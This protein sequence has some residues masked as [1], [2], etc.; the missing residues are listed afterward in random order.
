MAVVLA[1]LASGWAA[2]TGGWIHAVEATDQRQNRLDVVAP[3]PA[4]GIALEQSF[5]A[6]HNGLAAVEL[7]LASSGNLSPQPATLTLRLMDDDNRQLA[8]ASWDPDQLRHN[9]PLRFNFAPIRNSAGQRFRLLLEG[10]EGNRVTV[11]AFSLDGYQPGELVSNDQ[12]QTGD[13]YFRTTYRYRLADALH[14]LCRFLR[15]QAGLGVVLLLL[16]GVPGM[17]LLPRRWNRS[18]DLGVWL[19][20][21]VASSLATMPLGWLWLTFVGGRWRPA[22][23]W[24]ALMA[25][26]LVVL[27]RGQAGHPRRALAWHPETGWLALVVIA[28]LAVRLL[29]VRDLVLPAWVD[30]PQHWMIAQLMGQSGQVLSSYRPVMPVDTFWYH[31]GFHALVATVWQMTEAPLEQILLWGGQMLNAMVPLSVYAASVLLTNRRP[32]GLVAAFFVALVGLFPGYY[33]TWGRYTQLTGMLL[34]GP[35]LGVAWQYLR[36]AGRRDRCSS[37]ADAFWLALMLGGLAL[38]HAR[39][40][41]FALIWC[42]LAALTMVLGRRDSVRFVGRAWVIRSAMPI[43]LSLVVAAPWLVRIAGHVL[44]RLV[45][46]AGGSGPAGT[47]NAFPWAYL[48][49]GWERYWLIAAAVA[50]LAASATALSRRFRR[51]SAGRAGAMAVVGGWVA[52]LLVAVNLDRL[53][54]PSSSFVNN[55]SVAI[56]LFLPEALLLGWL[57]DACG[58]QAAKHGIGRVLAPAL[59]SALT[60]LAGTMGAVQGLGVV[61]QDTIL[62][63]PADLEMIRWVRDNLPAGSRVAVN[64]WLW[65]PEHNWAGSDGGYWLWLLADRETTMPPLGYGYDPAYLQQINEFNRQ[66]MAVTAWDAPETAGLLQSAGVTHLFAGERG[67]AL[68]PERLAASSNYRLLATNGTAWVFGFQAADPSA[69]G[70]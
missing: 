67:G 19:G 35:L 26:L 21:A 31:W 53:G 20:L 27:W 24:L 8:F 14:D 47:Y 15:R 66:L 30:S 48:S 5:L 49:H 62:A 6:V 22:S 7:L 60:V 50:W 3:T 42:F 4:P 61:N 69:N 38:V 58:R 46:L 28:G 9:D 2:W 39:V 13:L 40:W 25:L 37:A 43:L 32:A 54:V 23:L 11:W 12:P 34:L 1:L 52:A 59:L 55:N 56:S 51:R 65:L 36:A 41:V 57:V 63:G 17:A 68:R 16:L 29:A 44:P 45:R 10:T 70:R 33:V 64:A 18:G